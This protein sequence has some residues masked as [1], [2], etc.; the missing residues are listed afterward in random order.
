MVPKEPKTFKY[1]PESR[2]EEQKLEKL[3]TRR[4][5]PRFTGICRWGG[6]RFD[7]RE[8]PT[9][10]QECMGG[11][12]QDELSMHGLLEETIQTASELSQRA[13]RPLPMITA[14]LS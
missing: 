12:F 11:N 6:H 7:C 13:R 2:S 1:L 5:R 3:S 9:G 10:P 14:L 8:L 4:G